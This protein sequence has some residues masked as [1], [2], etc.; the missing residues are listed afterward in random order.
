K[1]AD[2]VRG[3]VREL[4]PD[5]DARGVSISDAAASKDP[6]ATDVRD[7]RI[8]GGVPG[9]AGTF[10]VTHAGQHAT[11]AKVQQLDVASPDPAYSVRHGA[12]PMP[13]GLD[14]APPVGPARGLAVY[15]TTEFE[16]VVFRT[17]DGAIQRVLSNRGAGGTVGEQLVGATFSPDGERVLVSTQNGLLGVWSV[18][19]GE[20]LL[21]LRGHE[22]RATRVVRSDAT[23]TICSVASDETARIWNDL[24]TPLWIDALERSSGLPSAARETRESLRRPRLLGEVW[25]ELESTEG[26]IGAST[27][28][29]IARM[30]DRDP[31]DPLTAAL[32]ALTVA[33]TELRRSLPPL[34]TFA[35][36]SLP[37]DDPRQPALRRVRSRYERARL[38]ADLTGF[39]PGV[40]PAELLPKPSVQRVLVASLAFFPWLPVGRIVTVIEPWITTGRALA[41]R[42]SR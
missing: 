38:F 29:L 6:G 9:D 42:I 4:H 40:E 31:G 17:S 34:I 12:T 37:P 13:T 20:H 16:A 25:A 1:Q 32:H 39:A 10:R 8:W 21:D 22:T 24:S 2:L 3:E 7:L 35:S 33:R 5:G 15:T 36:R 26:P 30:Y 41:A 18:V 23:G 11:W 14:V 28:L 27:E 19:T